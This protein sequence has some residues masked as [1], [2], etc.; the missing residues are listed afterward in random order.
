MDG[1]QFDDLARA[2][3]VGVSRRRTF[4]VLGAALTGSSLLAAVPENAGAL[5]RRQQ[6]RCK[7][8]GG[9]VCSAG[10]KKS[11]CCASKNGPE[12]AGTCVNGACSCDSTQTFAETNG[13]PRSANGQCGCF[14]YA[15]A[16][17][18]E[19]ACADPGG[20]NLDD[21]CSSN[22]DCDPGTVCQPNCPNVG[23]GHCSF[24]CIPA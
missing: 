21:P 14:S 22:A 12:G 23:D 13:C 11:Q 6:R 15:G 17:T 18:S 16:G 20:C 10:T 1:H 4:M 7:R 24:P 5:S 3:G 9:T 2:L 19:G 8:S